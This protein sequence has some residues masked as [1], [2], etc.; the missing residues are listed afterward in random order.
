MRMHFAEFGRRDVMLSSL[1]SNCARRCCGEC[2]GGYPRG[3]GGLQVAGTA[4]VLGIVAGRVE[5]RTRRRTDPRDVVHGGRA[6]IGR[7][8]RSAQGTGLRSGFCGLLFQ[9]Q[10]IAARLTVGR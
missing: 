1:F 6:P 3:M 7:R 2:A 8:E 10:D 5:T 4:I 9:N